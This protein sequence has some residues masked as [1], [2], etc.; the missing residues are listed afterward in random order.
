[1]TMLILGSAGLASFEPHHFVGAIL[2]FL[3][4]FALESG[5]RSARFLQQSHT[6]TDPVLW[7]CA[8]QHHQPER[9][10]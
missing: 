8:G 1:M 3:I 9:D 5:S 4:G 2:P 10:P 6:R 7:F